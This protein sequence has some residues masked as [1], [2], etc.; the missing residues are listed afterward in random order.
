MPQLEDSQSSDDDQGSLRRSLLKSKDKS[1]SVTFQRLKRASRR[2]GDSIHSGRD[3]GEFDDHLERHESLATQSEYEFTDSD[4]NS[5][6]TSRVSDSLSASN[7]TLKLASNARSAV[8]AEPVGF[9][10]E[11]GDLGNG[12]TPSTYKSALTLT[13]RQNLDVVSAVSDAAAVRVINNDSDFLLSGNI[14]YSRLEEM[15]RWMKNKNGSSLPYKKSEVFS[16]DAQFTITTLLVMHKYADLTNPFSWL[17]IGNEEDDRLCKLLLTMFS[18]T[19]DSPANS[20]DLFKEAKLSYDPARPDST[21]SFC[22][23][24]RKAWDLL[25]S[26]AR[27]DT[28]FQKICKDILKPIIVKSTPVVDNKSWGKSLAESMFVDGVYPTNPLLFSISMRVAATEI[29][30]AVA[31]FVKA[32]SK[33]KVNEFLKSPSNV[34]RDEKSRGSGAER[35]TSKPKFVK[36]EDR[37]PQAEAVKSNIDKVCDGCGRDSHSDKKLCG[38]KEHPDWNKSDKPFRH[39]DTYKKLQERNYHHLYANFRANGDR[40]DPPV[41]HASAKENGG[42]PIYNKGKNGG[43]APPGTGDCC[44]VTNLNNLTLDKND[45]NI[46]DVDDMYTI[47]CGVALNNTSLTVYALLDFGALQANYVSKDVAAWILQQQDKLASNSR[48]IKS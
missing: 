37:K 47:P 7:Q 12:A 2:E 48:G 43:A 30:K 29:S 17:D 5:N 27:T 23:Q 4:S 20:D 38:W 1:R 24:I 36:N 39:T 28:R 41:V 40:L 13:D 22:Q 18:K 46:S 25:P 10:F 16:E 34:K 35:D 9:S 6:K 19:V 32:T 14:T 15:R 31:I 45:V 42:A 44:T 8:S 33:E 26:E 21:N 11:R 3:S